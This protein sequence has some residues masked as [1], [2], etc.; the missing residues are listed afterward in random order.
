MTAGR[1]CYPVFITFILTLPYGCGFP[2]HFKQNLQESSE[3]YNAP[4]QLSGDPKDTGILLVDAFKKIAFNEMLLSGVAVVD[5]SGLQKPIT[6]GS[7]RRGGF[8]SQ[9]S[10]VVVIPN[11]RPG[12][13]RI[14]KIKTENVNVWETLPLPITEEFEVE[15]RAGEPTYFGRIHVKQ[16]FASPQR[17]ITI[18][19]DKNREAESWKMVA[20]KYSD[21]PWT[22]IIAKR[23][24]VLK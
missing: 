21:S 8:L 13:Y 10:G 2:E 18:Q 15:V 23:I 7:F 4:E 17:E 11:L 6:Y 14:V 3:S 24:A 16:P 20:D 1:L 19:Y 12:T 9:I 5:T 22:T